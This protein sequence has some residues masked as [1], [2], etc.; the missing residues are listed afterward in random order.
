M[1]V[2]I[3]GLRFA[4]DGRVVLDVPTLLVR[5]NC[6]TAV[7]GPNGAGK[8]T[9]LR[10]IAGLEPAAAGRIVIVGDRG[11]EQRITPPA[12]AYVFQ[13]NVFLQQSV[14]ANLELGL[15]LRRLSAADRARR[16]GDAAAL[17]G[18]THLLERRADRLS[19]GEGRRAS[20]A[21]ALCLRAPLV[22]LDEPLAGLDPPTYARL[23]DDLPQVIGAFVGTTILVTHDR[24]EAL[25]LGDD[26]VV[27]A[28]GQ[29]RAA[30]QTRDVILNP[31][32][33]VVAEILGYTVLDGAGGRVA[34]RPGA[35]QPGAGP[36]E[37]WMIV[38]NVVELIER[39][40]ILG[41]I[42]GVRARAA[43][44]AGQSLRAGD[45]ILVHAEQVCRLSDTPLV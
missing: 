9:L 5:G 26:L 23:L 17:L 29:V 19:I 37:F 27:L 33:T 38:D 36:F 44:P 40:E 18:I 32:T 39:R 34:V 43:A 42:N 12:I 30:G 35:L 13:E 11:R 15:R 1:D 45:R 20:L 16:I 2:R 21:R 41:R 3:D 8:T 10:V 25:R 31:A 4:R 24:E 28:G 22:L 6:T 14:R 7:L